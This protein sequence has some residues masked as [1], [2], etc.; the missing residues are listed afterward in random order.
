MKALCAVNAE[1]LGQPQI[2]VQVMFIIPDIHFTYIWNLGNVYGSRFTGG[3]E[4]GST[5]RSS[6]GAPRRRGDCVAP[7]RV[8]KSETHLTDRRTRSI[9]PAPQNPRS[10]TSPP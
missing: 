2:T 6:I 5:A 9:K 3:G 1:N 8:V 4:A 7:D 10:R